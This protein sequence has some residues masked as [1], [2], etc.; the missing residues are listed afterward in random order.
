MLS[1]R[2]LLVLMFVSTLPA[3]AWAAPFCVQSQGVPPQCDYY[4]AAQC[5]TR[6]NELNGFCTANRSEL[7]ITSGGNNKYCL[8]LS[9]R[10]TQCLYADRN[11]CEN[12]ASAA[13][14]VCIEKTSQMVQEDPYR[15]DVNRT[16]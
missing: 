6:A 8:V 16:Y 2:K 5:R 9:S 4:D 10:H 3:S 13:N 12:D 7:V 1:T 11:T 14:G 15:Y